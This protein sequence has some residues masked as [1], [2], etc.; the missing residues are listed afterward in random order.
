[1]TYLKGV[2]VGMIA[3]LAASVIYILIALV[4]PLVIPFLLS[5]ITGS[6]GMAAASISSGPILAIAGVAFVAGF[7]WQFR[8]AT[9]H[10]P[11]ARR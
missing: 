8:R 7:F 1:M 6:G 2:V 4:F 5:R 9:E 10:R 11:R 3:A